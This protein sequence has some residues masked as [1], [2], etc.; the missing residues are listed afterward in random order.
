MSAAKNLSPCVGLCK[1]DKDDF[2]QGCR[3]HIEEI[4]SWGLLS[5]EAQR[6]ILALLP[7]R[8]AVSSSLDECDD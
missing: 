8:R 6:K 5:P 2:C 3:R 1:L 7:A 4:K